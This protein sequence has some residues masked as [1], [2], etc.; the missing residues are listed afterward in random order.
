MTQHI[1]R[2]HSSSRIRF[3]SCTHV[4]CVRDHNEDSLLASAP[5][6][7]VAD[8]M[9]GHEGGEIASEIAIQMLRQHAPRTPDAQALGAVI[10]DANMEIIKAAQDGRGR[11]GMG[12]TMTAAILKDTRLVI[13]QVGDSR[14]YLF[15]QG[16]LH[17]LTR[18]HSLM[19]D[20][21]DSGQ[22]TP[23]EAR[24]HPNR[25][26]ITRALGS[27]LYTQPDLYE[28][29]VQDNDRLL[30][31]SDGLSSVV[32]RSAIEQALARYDDPQICAEQLIQ[33]ALDAGGPDN[34]TAIVIDI[35]SDSSHHDRARKK[36]RR[37]AIIVFLAFILVLAGAGF[38]V[39]AW[40]DNSAYLADNEGKV[41]IYKG[42]NGELFGHRFDHLE[43]VT[44]INTHDLAPGVAA[45]LSG[46]GIKVNGLDAA[47]D[48]VAT[49][50]KEIESKKNNVVSSG[51]Q[52]SSENSSVASSVA[53]DAS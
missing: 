5:L 23:E 15:S 25:S 42:V 19:A 10:E 47:E 35:G 43:R 8:G 34:I 24:I 38:G 32:E 46:E 52:T 28:L 17:K 40:I 18:D 9:G 53:E 39:F 1:E 48:L 49:Y 36:S 4:G 50:E 41:A 12:T 6:F 14:A 27:S 11:E 31:C 3:G 37:T 13:A 26:V 2:T 44:A 29:N 16:T 51:T 21:I 45:R 22:I 33:E 7:A 30:L 20:M